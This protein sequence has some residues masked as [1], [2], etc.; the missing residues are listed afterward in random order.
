MVIVPIPLAVPVGRERIVFVIRDDRIVSATQSRQQT[1][2]GA[3]GFGYGPCGG[4][5]GAFSL[6]G[7]P[8]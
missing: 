7:F 8:R 1:V 5:F 4:T 6:E 3:V 2:G